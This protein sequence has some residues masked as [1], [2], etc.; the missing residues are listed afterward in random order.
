M[1]DYTKQD[2]SLIWAELGDY[3]PPTNDKI[4][5]G[6]LVEVPPRQYW[7]W[8]ENRQDK[9]LAYLA[10]KGIPEWD[11]A[12]EYRINKSYTQYNGVV[13]RCVRTNTNVIPGTS[14]LDW[15]VAFTT[16]TAATEALKAVTPA[17]DRIPYFNG[18]T[19]ATTA[20]LTAFARTILDDA[21]AS[22]VR[23]T[24]SAQASSTNLTALSGLT[25]AI[26]KLPYFTGS[27][28]A[29]TTDLSAFGR[30]LIDDAD[31]ATARATL[32]AN[33]A[34]NLTAG[35]LPDARLSGTYTGVSI[36]GNAATATKFATPRTINGVSF[37]GSANITIEDST[38]LPLNANA[39]SASKLE[40]ARTIN[41][42]AFDGTANITVADDT[43]LPLVGGTLT[44]KVITTA[45]VTGSASINLPH[46]ATPT[47]LVN[48]DTWTTTSGMYVRINGVSRDLYHAGNLVDVSQAE[49]EA[50]TAT[51]RRAWTAQRVRQAVATSN[52]ASATLAAEATKLQIPR[53]ING[54]PFDGTSDI[55]VPAGMDLAVLHAN[56]LSF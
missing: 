2:M 4:T 43:K 40:T 10:Q 47:T 7:N 44:G 45:P 24:I 28:T 25:S 19:T 36:T 14:T 32:G 29:A 3:A 15:V 1:V 51:T 33:N 31:A 30:S 9:M 8:I 55:V 21:D 11:A 39:V 38:K 26:N 37:D 35:I 56:A 46:G 52:A 17:A 13:Y 22:A 27:G 50:G 5:T 20:T 53:T 49:A 18:T 23:T 6:W 48:G 41:G 42:V 34:A 54:I 16:S 12:T